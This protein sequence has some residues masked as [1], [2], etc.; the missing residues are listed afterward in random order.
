MDPTLYLDEMQ[1]LLATTYDG[2]QY[3]CPLICATLLRYGMT[4]RVLE[5]HAAKRCAAE[6][7]EFRELMRD[8]VPDQVRDMQTL[9]RENLSV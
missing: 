8:V 2:I 7:A 4:R 6:R 5:R 9:C 3:S 1:E